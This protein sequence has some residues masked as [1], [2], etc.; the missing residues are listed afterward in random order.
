MIPSQKILIKTKVGLNNKYK[1]RY[2]DLGYTD[3][4]TSDEIYVD[5]ED[6]S[7]MSHKKIMVICDYC[8]EKFFV[9]YNTY[10]GNKKKNFNHKD[11]CENCKGL[12]FKET[13]NLK[14]GVD[15]P[16]QLDV[17]KEKREKTY[18]DKYGVNNPSSA[19]EIKIKKINTFMERYGVINSSQMDGFR[20]KFERTSME[21]YGVKHPFQSEVVKKLSRQTNLEKYGY[22]N[23][24]K[25]P[26]I[27][28]KII[29]SQK[30]HFSC[31]TS[32]VQIDL[33]KQILRLGYKS[34]LNYAESSFLLDIA[35]FVND[36]KIDI[37]YD[38]WYWHRNEQ[39]DNARN[40]VLLKLGWKVI[41]IQSGT[42]L[43]TDDELIR[44][45]NNA[46]NGES[47]Q[48]ITLKDWVRYDEK[49]KEAI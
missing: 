4:F 45:I 46:I 23:P 29:T 30:E 44:C 11:C 7:P 42:C 35:L 12:K 24:S 26:E 28:N 15:A 37:E 41:R 19:P 33:Y 34:E 10:S 22:E 27:I 9:D 13:C 2:F 1:Q 21:H 17:C 40:S 6:L 31:K 5:I 48:F 20:E 8:G 16:M 38:G 32:Q 43:P 25:S 36:I 47:I 3:V 49:N 39:K 14:Y 18:L